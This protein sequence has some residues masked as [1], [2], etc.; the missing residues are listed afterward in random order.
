[1]S[2]GNCSAV[3]VSAFSMCQPQPTKIM[4]VWKNSSTKIAMTRS[5]SRKS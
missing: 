5:Q 2:I 4:P 1:M 3:R